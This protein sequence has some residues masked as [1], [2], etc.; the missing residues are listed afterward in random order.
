[1]KQENAATG[2]GDVQDSMLIWST[3]AK[4]P[5]GGT[6]HTTHLRHLKINAV[7]F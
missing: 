2:D 5:K 1:V 6:G 7:E 4:F 3:D